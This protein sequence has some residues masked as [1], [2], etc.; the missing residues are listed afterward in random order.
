[1]FHWP[2]GSVQP[3]ISDSAHSIPDS[4]S[5]EAA[6]LVGPLSVGIGACKRAYIRPGSL[7]L[8]AGAGPIG[9]IM[10][11]TA[12]AFGATKIYIADVDADRRAFAL[13][14]GATIALDPLVDPLV[15]AVD[16]LDVDAFIDAFID[17]SAVAWQYRP[18][19]SRCGRVAGQFSLG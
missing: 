16:S 14:H 10:A 6:A 4:I 7:V 15:D 17:A 1:M 3:S 8:I 18:E 9:V 19:Y 11:Q 12:R 5:D 2:F 13:E